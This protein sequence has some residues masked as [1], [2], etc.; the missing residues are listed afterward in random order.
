MT[1][2]FLYGTLREPRLLSVVL[3]RDVSSPAADGPAAD[4]P[5]ADGPAADGA[6]EGARKP[7]GDI[8]IGPAMLPDH[9]VMAV[10]GQDFPMIVPRPGAQAAGVLVEG[11]D[12]RAFKRLRYY[13][14]GHGYALV[15][16]SVTVGGRAR[17][18]RVF[19]P[20]AGRWQGR[21]AW[22]FEAWRNDRA[23]L[24][25]VAAQEVMAHFGLRPPAEVFAH[26][27]S[28][29][30]AAQ[31]RLAARD[32]APVALRRGYGPGDVEIL[33][34]RRPYLG[35]FALQEHRLRHRRF[36]GGMSAPVERA[37]FQLA[38][39]VTILPYDP[40]NDLVLLVEQFRAGPSGRGDPHPWCLEPVAGRRDLGES[41]ADCARRELYEETGLTDVRL[42][43]IAGYYSSPGAVSEHITSYLGICALDPAFEGTYGL[44]SENEDIRSIIL[45]FDALMQAVRTGEADNGPLLIS[46]LWLARERP[47]LRAG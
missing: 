13:E 28:I 2:L 39:A 6:E 46:A 30:L 21:G 31:S 22:D 40:R 33:K 25:I 36:D 26:Y 38:D 42:E 47:R 12:T 41:H 37:I 14:G 11:L 27:P 20:E 32:H 10:E 24:A 17:R 15:S 4:G 23:P 29:L 1:A 3:G 44:E 7:D 8:A 19:M 45:P 16:V 5:A 18:A 34:I 35:F 43:P 9:A